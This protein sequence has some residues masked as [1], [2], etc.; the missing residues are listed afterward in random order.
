[1]LLV[2]MGFLSQLLWCFFEFYF[3]KNL[4]VLSAPIKG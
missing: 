4:T 3:C 2:S 1:L